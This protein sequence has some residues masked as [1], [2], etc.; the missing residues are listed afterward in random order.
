MLCSRS[1]H[2][3]G[4]APQANIYCTMCKS[5]YCAEC[6]ANFH[7]SISPSHAQ[8]VT[9]SLNVDPFTG[10]CKTHS[11]SSLNYFCCT[12]RCLCCADCQLNGGDHCNCNIIPFS[13]VDITRTKNDLW[14]AIERIEAGIHGVRSFP[15]E[16]FDEKHAAYEDRTNKVA[17]E[18]RQA[19]NDIREAID[20]KEAELLTKI[21]EFYN[22]S[23]GDI[24]NIITEFNNID[25][26]SEVLNLAKQIEHT[27]DDSK[28]K[29]MVQKTSDIV[30]AS[31]KL[32][33]LI[34]RSIDIVTNDITFSVT[35]DDTLA[36]AI[37]SC[38]DVKY[39]SNIYVPKLKVESVGSDEA[40]FSWND[41]QVKDTVYLIRA[42][43]TNAKGAYNLCECTD[44]KCTVKNLDPDTEYLFWIKVLLGGSLGFSSDT[45]L[46]RT[47]QKKDESMADWAWAQCPQGVYNSSAYAINENKPT[48]IATKSGDWGY[49]T[50]IGN[51]HI[52]LNKV[53]S[54]DIKVRKSRDGNG[55]FVGVAPYDINQ[56]EDNTDKYGWYFNCYNSALVS[57][58]PH[59]YRGDKE[60]GP[61]KGDGHYIRTGK[62]VGVVMDTIKSELSFVLDKANYGAAYEG[63]PLDKPLVP[64]VLL[65]FR[66]DSVELLC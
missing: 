17:T 11:G 5:F 38:G 21:E 49:S 46:I 28:P 37:A 57:G 55:V 6:E 27:W 36:Q 26:V 32:E 22:E 15:V 10:K 47:E 60:Y 9:H 33:S 23:A 31:M 18:I 14:Y 66:N 39:S 24:D 13:S 41:A 16:I 3:G 29:E 64:C 58:P 43:K 52:L 8:Y 50:I 42:K 30:N 19:F 51:T 61:R 63:I 44:Q 2:A 35:I 48:R 20:R 53:S 34:K 54:W 56:N 59:N 45:V 7:D 4:A 40:T 62:T 12:H 65:W 1:I 25:E